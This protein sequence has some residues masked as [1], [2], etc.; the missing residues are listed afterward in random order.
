LGRSGQEKL[1]PLNSGIHVHAIPPL[2]HATA[3]R[4]SHLPTAVKHKRVLNHI[5]IQ[6][7]LFH[8]M[9]FDLAGAQ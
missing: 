7:A 9:H 8:H 6:A 3:N 4:K 5:W 1:G 2:L